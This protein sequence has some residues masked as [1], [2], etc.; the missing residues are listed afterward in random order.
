MKKPSALAEMIAKK[1]FNAANVQQ[2]WQVHMQA[3]GPILA[4]AYA[5]CYTAKIH[6]TNILNKIS[7][8][9][10]AG[11]LEVMNTLVRSCGCEAAAD[12]AL[13]C[14]MKGLCCEV[15]GNMMGMFG[16]YTQAGY[17]GA[18]FYLLH[19]KNAKFAQQAGQLDI[20]LE[21]YYKGISCLEEAPDTPN[22][23]LLLASTIVNTASC[24]TW[25]HRF[26]DAE[27]ALAQARQIGPVSRIGTVEAVLMAA[28]DR[29]DELE[30]CLIALAEADDPDYDHILNLTTA[31]INGEDPHFEPQPVNDEAI[32]AFWQWFAENEAALL[33]L[34]NQRDEELPE[35]FTSQMIAHLTPCFPFEQSQRGSHH[36]LTI[37]AHEEDET[38][39]LYFTDY[40]SRSLC[41]GYNDLFAA[42][43]EAI[44]ARWTWTLEH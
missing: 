29:E 3:F 2:S 39:E 20:A 4:P 27:A 7:R 22:Q 15:S 38:P 37:A 26:R 28:M 30:S 25:M 33:E 16:H 35:A 23:R 32:A 43:P 8:R 40:Y 24:L 44:A 18:R 17:H 42:C 36:P 9:D 12:K 31:I 41:T 6:I 10:V 21:E 14:F 19:L 13:L 34:Y 1:A 11:A 5:D